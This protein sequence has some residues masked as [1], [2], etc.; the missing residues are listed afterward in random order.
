MSAASLSG[1]HLR[2]GQRFGPYRIDGVLGVGGM[3]IVYRAHDRK[4]RRTVAIKLVDRSDAAAR[5]SLLQEARLAASLSHPA[6]CAVHEVGCIR[7]QPYVVM[8]YVAG[9]PLSSMLRGGQGIGLESVL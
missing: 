5:R 8:E 7:D 1:V 6:I 9:L 4:L 2:V 3:G